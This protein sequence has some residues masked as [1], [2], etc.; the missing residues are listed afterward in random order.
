MMASNQG[1]C[2]VKIIGKVASTDSEQ[3]AGSD[4]VPMT[5]LHLGR[6]AGSQKLYVNIDRL[7][8]GAKSCK[9][10]SHSHQE[11]FF[12]ILR[13]TCTAVVGEQSY[14]LEEGS[15]LAKP[16]GQGIAHQ[17]INDSNDIV[18]ILDVGTID[19]NDVIDYP[20][21]GVSYIPA[22]MR[23]WKNGHELAAWNSDPNVPG[24]SSTV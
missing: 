13:G 9:L 19:P 23:A 4:G 18:E 7:Q 2:A 6:E 1:G 24:E 8:P 20:D 10:H 17:F 5:T 14:I 11:E 21:E 16:A 15:F 3:I 22:Q 12:M